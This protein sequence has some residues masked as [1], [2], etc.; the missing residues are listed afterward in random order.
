MPTVLSRCNKFAILH[1]QAASLLA[2][3]LQISSSPT[4]WSGPVLP[5]NGSR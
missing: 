3:H 5:S 4:P 1:L 2:C